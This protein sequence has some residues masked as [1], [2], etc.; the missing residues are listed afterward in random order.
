[1][2]IARSSI[3]AVRY[4]DLPNMESHVKEEAGFSVY[5]GVVVRWDEDYDTRIIDFIDDMDPDD[6]TDLFSVQEHKGSISFRWKNSVPPQF[7]EG[8][9]V[10][11]RDG[12]TWSVYESTVIN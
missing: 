8:Q 11:S 1:M 9:S 2:H 12:D 4:R 5:K 6:V 7:A 3:L 10:D